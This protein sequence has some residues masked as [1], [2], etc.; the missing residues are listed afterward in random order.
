M[1]SHFEGTNKINSQAITTLLQ[2]HQFVDILFAAPLD[3]LA[4]KTVE[5]RLSYDFK[6]NYFPECLKDRG[7]DDEVALPN[8]PYRD[9]GILIWN[10]INE[11]VCE[12]ID[13]YYITSSSIDLDVNLQNWVND[14]L[15]NAKIKGFTKIESKIELV[16]VLTMII[17]TASAQHAAVNF[18]QPEWVM[19]SPYSI[20]TLKYPKP[21][22]EDGSNMNSWLDMMPSIYR[23]EQKIRIY[24]LL[25]GVYHGYLGEYVNLN[26][27]PIF[28]DYLV[29]K[30][31]GPLD[32]FRNRLIEIEA[33][34]NQR[35]NSRKYP[36][37]YLLPSKI[38]ASTNI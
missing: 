35:N 15:D 22:S 21:L 25:G 36:Y 30:P 1:I 16:D 12:Y 2:Q 37:T 27:D 14:I 5:A 34:I 9:D 31:N 8:Y 3:K 32:K 20:G 6:A 23:S 26:G 33:E 13:L 10:A 7:V 29:T 28:D 17:F 19:Y 18:A 11:W 38:P 24:S 4:S